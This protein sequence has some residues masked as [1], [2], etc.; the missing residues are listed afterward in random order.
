MNL[1]IEVFMFSRR[2]ARCPKDTF[3]KSCHSVNI[4]SGEDG[5]GSA[6]LFW[7][8]AAVVSE[9]VVSPV[10][11][12]VAMIGARGVVS[13]VVVSTVVVVVVVVSLVGLV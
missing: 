9:E 1:S 4:T 12:V 8:V 6:S 2:R 11:V 5:T 13:V 10:V 7:V 3:S